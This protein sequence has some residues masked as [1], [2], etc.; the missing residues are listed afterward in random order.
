MCHVT[1]C[2]YQYI[3]AGFLFRVYYSFSDLSALPETAAL[4]DNRHYL[5]ITPEILQYWKLYL[6]GMLAAMGRLVIH[7]QTAGPAYGTRHLLVNS[8]ITQRC[9]PFTASVNGKGTADSGMIRA[10][11][12]NRIGNTNTGNSLHCY[13]A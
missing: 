4:Q 7:Y 5:E 8:Y 11:D 2:Y 10:Y 1:A 6:Y 9:M 12:Y 3:R 13:R